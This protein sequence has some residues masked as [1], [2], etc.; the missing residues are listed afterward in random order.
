MQAM[1]N[2][3][4][5]QPN[6][7]GVYPFSIAGRLHTFRIAANVDVKKSTLQGILKHVDEHAN[8]NPNADIYSDAILGSKPRSGRPQVLTERDI[9]QLIHHCPLSAVARRKQWYYD[10]PDTNA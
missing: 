5:K 6:P 7:Q 4:L 3:G 10:D 2:L 1:D 9:R 8:A